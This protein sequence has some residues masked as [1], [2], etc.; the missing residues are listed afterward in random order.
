M[1]QDFKLT[2]IERETPIQVFRRLTTPVR[3]FNTFYTLFG[4]VIMGALFAAAFIS[5]KLHPG[6]CPALFAV[7]GGSSCVWGVCYGAWADR[8]RVWWTVV[9]A[10]GSLGMLASGFDVLFTTANGGLLAELF[11]GGFGVI[12]VWAI[13]YAI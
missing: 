4:F 2:L 1:P 7:A 3:L 10:L 6:Y 11:G 13:T 9:A 12:A 5:L 8:L